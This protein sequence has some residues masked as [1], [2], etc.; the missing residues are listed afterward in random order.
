MV[1]SIES[2]KG[3]DGAAVQLFY[4]GDMG[5]TPLRVLGVL[6][7]SSCDACK[8]MRY[9][10][11]RIWRVMH[12]QEKGIGQQKPVC[13]PCQ[14]LG[15]ECG[16]D[17]T[18]KWQSVKS[19]DSALPPLRNVEGW[20][21][22][23]ISA[24]H[25]DDTASSLQLLPDTDSDDS[26]SSPSDG[27]TSEELSLSPLGATNFNPSTHG[28]GV[29]TPCL[30]QLYLNPEESHLWSYFHQRI[31]PAC[32][33]DP[34]LNPYQDVILRIAASTGNMSPLFRSIMAISSSQLYILGNQDYYSSSWGYRHQALRALRLETARM[35]RDILDQASEAQILATVMALVFLDI[36]SDCSASWVV[37]AS[38]ARSLIY[39]LRCGYQNLNPD[40]EALLNFVGGYIIVH[41]VYAHTAWDAA[42]TDVSGGPV[43][44]MCDDSNLQTLTGCSTEFIQILADIN[45]LVSDYSR[46][47]SLDLVDPGELSNL[48]HRRHH[49]EMQLHARAPTYPIDEPGA[50]VPHSALMIEAKRLTGLLHLYSR[51]D[52]L[53]PRDACISDLSSRILALIRR[54]PARSNTILW[55]LFM[56]ATLGMGPDRD[57]DRAFVL[58][59]LD[60]LQRERQMRY[61]KKARRII[62]EVW[63][64][65]DLREPETRMGWNIL[66]QVGKLER[67]SL[68]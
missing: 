62:V 61:I 55:P 32:V 25:F 3:D 34:A 56:V 31:A 53:G 9:S 39:K 2:K 8:Q 7:G 37:H 66:R 59:T 14:T 68:L 15:L 11:R 49:L 12:P 36:L 65:R 64:I 20:M 45:T 35:E 43:T 16:Y 10:E 28:F 50:D 4:Q 42:V 40:I 27:G 19:Y 13:R 18:L 47:S 41:E 46:Y 29:I 57:A 17:R 54:L 44:I 30:S 33:L 23:H 52:H 5:M 60:S 63:K 67:I 21:F 51:A 1:D 6:V 26:E 22:L 24:L 38:F 48:E 58:E